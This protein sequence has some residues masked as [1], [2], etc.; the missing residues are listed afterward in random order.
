MKIPY[1]IYFDRLSMTARRECHV[2][3][4]ET[5]VGGRT[6]NFKLPFIMQLRNFLF[7]AL[8]TTMALLS[9]CSSDIALVKR[10]YMPGYHLD[11]SNKNKQ[12][13]TIKAVEEQAD[14][15]TPMAS[16]SS[17]KSIVTSAGT[18]NNNACI[19]SV[20]IPTKKAARIN[21]L[22]ANSESL[23]ADLRSATIQHNKS[24]TLSVQDTHPANDLQQEKSAGIIGLLFSLILLAIGIALI[25]AL[26]G[27]GLIIGIVLLTLGIIWLILKL[28][29]K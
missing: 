2:E 20:S 7:I 1:A 18:G 28:I 11:I 9:S 22:L 8:A 4:L 5:S 23:V 25:L 17:R 10:H 3:A 14:T 19:P 24:N 16:T 12:N 29:V 21:K 15:S 26:S 13:S 6:N 27:V